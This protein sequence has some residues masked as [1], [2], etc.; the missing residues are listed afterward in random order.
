MLRVFLDESGDTGWTFNKPYMSG[1]SSR[2]LTLAYMLIP[3]EEYK[4]AKRMLKT[5]CIAHKIPFAAEPKGTY[6]NS[7]RLADFVDQAKRLAN[8]HPHIKYH[9]IT[10]CKESVLEH[11]R[12]DPNKLYNY[13]LRL[14]LL[15]KIDQEESVRLIPDKRSIKVKSGNSMVDYLQTI[16]WT[17]LGSRTKIINQPLESKNCKGLQIAHLLANLVWRHYELSDSNSYRVLEPH[18]GVKHLFF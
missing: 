15:G 11:I 14:S 17:E 4:H 13:M 7:A 8:D 2:Y 16:L 6:I 12:E 9:A 3:Q 1:G 5:F 10:V 18:I